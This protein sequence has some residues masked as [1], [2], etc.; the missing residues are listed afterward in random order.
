MQ[1][2]HA[3]E[4]FRVTWPIFEICNM[5]FAVLLLVRIDIS[6]FPVVHCPAV[7]EISRMLSRDTVLLC[8]SQLN[9]D[10]ICNVFL[11]GWRLRYCFVA[12]AKVTVSIFE[13]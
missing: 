3:V 2:G 12:R 1:S 5:T 8:P 11:R 6:V 9:C 4:K 7:Q 13:I 10:E